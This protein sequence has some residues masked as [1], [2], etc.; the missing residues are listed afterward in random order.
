MAIYKCNQC[1]YF[2][3]KS[4]WPSSYYYC[5]KYKIKVDY[6]KT[7]CPEMKNK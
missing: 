4:T 6:N 1:P 5:N 3:K 7:V 2:E